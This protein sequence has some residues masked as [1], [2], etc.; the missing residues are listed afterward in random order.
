MPKTH[1]K[2]IIFDTSVMKEERNFKNYSTKRLKFIKFNRGLFKKVNSSLLFIS[3]KKWF[4]KKGILPENPHS[5][6]I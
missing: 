4:K 1:H 3:I 6:F 2:K 5:T